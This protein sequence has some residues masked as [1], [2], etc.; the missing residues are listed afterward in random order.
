MSEQK[1][2]SYAY[3]V[4]KTKDL[5][6]R[7]RIDV[8]HRAPYYTHLLYSL[9]PVMCPGYGTIGVSEELHL[10]IDPVRV[11]LDPE[12]SQVDADGI[13]KKLA[14]SLVHEMQHILR[15]IERVHS[16][17]Q[18]DPE[19]ANIAAD[20]PINADERKTGW[21]LPNW[22]VYPDSP[23]YNFPLGLTM[24]GYF[25]LLMENP[26]AYK[27]K[28][29]EMV[30]AAKGQKAQDGD[31]LDIGA[32][33]CGGVGGN[34]APNPAQQ[35]TKNIPGRSPA[36]VEGAIKKTAKEAQDFFSSE[37]RGDCPAWAEEAIKRKK[38]R[39][40]DW[41]N[42]LNNV[43][44]RRAG[45]I[46]MGAADYSLSRPS[47]RSLLRGG[48]LRPGMVEQLYEAALAI[49]TSGSMGTDQL[50]YAK[51][52]ACNI[53]EQTGIDHL[54]LALCDAAITRE[55]KR[56]RLREID[57]LLMRGRGG[58]NFNPIFEALKSLRPKPDMLILI[59]DG[60]GPAPKVPPRGV[61]VIWL[62]VPSAWRR[63]PTRWGH[64]II[65]SNDHE[66]VDEFEEA[67]E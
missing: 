19:L 42:A 7:A 8:Q 65:A 21:E 40:R 64:Y 12:F 67:M 3:C 34:A 43:V 32:G 48:L 66:V 50:E 54:W 14:G 55:F 58:T 1:E 44:R 26:E 18:I 47:K 5:L 9:M 22:V 27:K 11:A 52:A 59:T 15:G 33:R 56:T 37:G 31:G 45:I 49:D 53:L 23:Q 63:R 46:Q 29:R 30:L 25:E 13:P 17:A 10:L 51:N 38:R 20:L 16:L 24:E 39:D 36:E 6:A 41:K 57:S 60:D 4:A 28:T 61:E 2:V 62:I 35:Q